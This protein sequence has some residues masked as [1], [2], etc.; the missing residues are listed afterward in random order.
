M[1]RKI[2]FLLMVLC[3]V[4]G[5]FASCTEKTPSVDGEVSV[6]TGDYVFKRGS[7]VTLVLSSEEYESENAETYNQLIIDIDAA[8][9]EGAAGLSVKTAMDTDSRVSRE[10]I[11]GRCDRELSRQ[12]YR[13]LEALNITGSDTGFVIYSNGTSVAIAYNMDDTYITPG[14]A[15]EYFV[16]NYVEGKSICAMKKGVVYSSTFSLAP[17]YQERD[18]AIVEKQWTDLWDKIY[19]EMSVTMSSDE[20]EEYTDDLIDALQELYSMYSD[21]LIS[22][23]ANLLEPLMCVCEG[24]CQNTKYCGGAGFYYSNSG[25]NTEGFLPDAESTAQAFGILQNSGM[26]GLVDGDITT[27]FTEE[28]IAGFIK[29]CKSLQDE[30]SGYFYH[31]QW[32]KEELSVSRLSRDMSYACS[33]LKTLG[34]APTYD[35]P[36][37]TSGDGISYDGTYVGTDDIVTPVSA[38]TGRLSKSSAAAVSSVVSSTATAAYPSY[39]ENDITYKA[40]LATLDLKGNSYSVG[41][42]ISASATQLIN[43]QKQL[44]AEGATYNLISITDSWFRTNQ[45][46]ETGTWDYTEPGDAGYDPYYGNDGVLKISAWYNDVGLAFPNPALAAQNAINAILCDQDIEHVCNLYNTWFAISN[47][48][49]NVTKYGSESVAKKFVND[50]RTVAA[51]GIRKSREKIADH[52]K[53]DGSF[54]YF[55]DHSSQTSQGMPVAVADTDEG[56]LNATCIATYGLVGYIFSA[57]DFGDFQDHPDI[58]TDSDRREFLSIVSELGAVIKNAEIDPSVPNTFDTYTVGDTVSKSEFG[59]SNSNPKNADN[60]FGTHFTIIKDERAGAIGN[61][62]QYYSQGKVDSTDY[63]SLMSTT[64]AGGNTWAYSVDLNL[65]EFAEYDCAPTD[66]TTGLPIW[67]D[68]RTASKGDAIYINMGQ[69]LYDDNIYMIILRVREVDGEQV[70]GIWDSSSDSSGASVFNHITDVPMGEWFNLKVEYYRIKTED[71]ESMRAKIYINNKVVFVSDNY[72]DRQGDKITGSSTPNTAFNRVWITTVDRNTTNLLIDNFAVYKFRKNYTVESL[73]I[74]KNVD[75]S[76]NDK[77]LYEFESEDG[78]PTDIET[79]GDADFTNGTLTITGGSMF[80]PA[81]IR[82]LRYNRASFEADITISGKNG[83][84]GYILF[85]DNTYA[86]ESIMMLGF[87]IVETVG[88]KYVQFYEMQDGVAG[89]NIS[90]ARFLLTNTVKLRIDFFNKEDKTLIYIDGE[91]VNQSDAKFGEVNKLTYGGAL[92]VMNDGYTIDIDNLVA[93]FDTCEVLD[94]PGVQLDIPENLEDFEV[95]AGSAELSGAAEVTDGAVKLSAKDSVI[96]LDSSKRSNIGQCNI[97]SASIALYDETRDGDLVRL[98]LKDETGK[99]LFAVEIA[100]DAEYIYAYEYAQGQRYSLALAKGKKT[101]SFNIRIEYYSDM[102]KANI[103]LNDIGMATTNI[104]YSESSPTLKYDRAE[105]TSLSI[106]P[107]LV[108]SMSADLVYRTFSS[109]GIDGELNEENG[110]KTVTFD[111]ALDNNLPS[112]VTG[113]FKTYG[114]GISIKQMLKRIDGIESYSKVGVYTMSAG[115]NDELKFLSS[116]TK[117]ELKKTSSVVF[118]GE[119]CVDSTYTST[120]WQI[121]FGDSTKSLVQDAAYMVCISA[122]SS[123]EVKLYEGSSTNGANSRTGESKVIADVGEW[124]KLRVEYYSGDDDTVRIKIFVNDVLLLVSDN[125]YRDYNKK[126]EPTNYINQ[127]NFYGQSRSYGTLYFDNIS[128]YAND[129]ETCTDAVTENYTYGASALDEYKR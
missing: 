14:E 12:A 74:E 65:T 41:N 117:T 72:F 70:V 32:N 125:Y 39:M 21:K 96:E 18:D 48:K 103:Y 50:L 63:I 47:L 31:P 43:R 93:D 80:V 57:L 11:I 34:S 56:D 79:T 102:D 68:H 25:R 61:V 101:D 99:I 113:V 97:L 36:N 104:S 1:K 24:E 86:R 54:S 67:T 121:I 111:Y 129:G 89:E 124:F 122:N 81:N 27:A 19:G 115:G 3:L 109:V 55:Q 73:P 22:W 52:Q 8:L 94:A 58:Y 106:Y 116:S 23:L 105:I 60:P 4:L 46:T 45:N 13:E 51:E 26:L 88:R 100:A 20:A 78:I 44:T 107:V 108:E 29:F 87:K 69:G 127:V 30:E 7:E 37:G 128:F 15:L 2:A 62:L 126:G 83:D 112:A 40:Y 123:G 114:A 6:V 119:F 85:V 98:A 71:S 76:G 35:A 118:E 75:G 42:Q 17:Y 64:G 5:S 82:S 59:I 16:D 66:S 49:I 110:A 95:D 92:V 90:G 120:L 33:V 9:R 91:L 28:Q 53:E 77:K 38:L 84:A 10:I